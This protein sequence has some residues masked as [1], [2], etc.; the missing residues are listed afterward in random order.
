VRGAVDVF[1]FQVVGVVVEAVEDIGADAGVISSGQDACR[2]AQPVA[3]GG[4]C[5]DADG[6]GLDEVAVGGARSCSGRFAELGNEIS[7]SCAEKAFRSDVK[8]GSM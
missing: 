4:T 3:P 2:R 5:Q 7:A 6:L 1:Q 8:P